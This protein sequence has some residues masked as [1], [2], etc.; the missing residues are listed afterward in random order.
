MHFNAPLW[1]NSLHPF[2]SILQEIDYRTILDQPVVIN[3]N[4]HLS[5]FETTKCLMEQSG[6]TN[7]QRFE[8]ID[9]FYTTNDFF[10]RLGIFGKVAGVGQKG[11][12]ASHLLVWEDFLKNSEKEFLFVAEDDML[13]HSDFLQLFPIYWNLTPP[14]FDILLV[15][16]Q[17]NMTPSEPYLVPEPAFCLHAYIISKKGAQKLLGLYKQVPKDDPGMCIIDI[18]M[19]KAMQQKKI[20]FYCY[21]GT[22]FPDKINHEAGNISHDRDTGICFQNAR[23]G[24]SI[25]ATDLIPSKCSLNFDVPIT[26]STDSI[27]Q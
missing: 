16:N 17:M 4:R 22:K 15:G 11:C 20:I 7:I 19:V 23:L 26:P 1:A 27:N 8:A 3:L 18:F 13:P 25:H 5:R 10:E 6:F 2:Y 21:N 14:F 12:A 9:G 24:S